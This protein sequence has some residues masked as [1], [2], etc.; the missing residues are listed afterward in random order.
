MDFFEY[1]QI[2]EYVAETFGETRIWVSLLVGGLC[3]AVVYGFQAAGLYIIAKREGYKHRWMAFV[4]FL[5]TY[6][7]GVLGQK[8][9]FFRLDT[10]A[11]AIVAA[12]V[13]AM[14]FTL[15]SLYFSAIILLQPY[16]YIETT[17]VEWYG[18]Q[19]QVTT[20]NLDPLITVNRPD[21]T[22]AVWC[23][24]YLSSYILSWLE[25]VY[26]LVSVVLLNCFFQTYSPAHYFLYTL[27]SII[28]PVQGI[29][30]F[31]VR[32]RRGISYAEYTRMLQEQIYRRYRSQ[33]NSDPYVGRD[34]YRP[35][36]MNGE[37]GGNAG[38]EAPSGEPFDEFGPGGGKDPFDE[39]KN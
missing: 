1:A 25:L 11:V 33:Q 7:I 23:Y 24:N 10:R 22:W 18:R 2:A 21:L 32:N 13:E 29:F 31:V 15:Y 14:L 36:D 28:F 26:L 37:T 6:Y 39:F 34:Q 9:R 5:N 4:P 38:D 19:L 20:T 3:F 17:V 30:I 27:G 8:N 35:G 16:E 12:V